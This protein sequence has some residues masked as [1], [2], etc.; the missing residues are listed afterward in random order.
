[1]KK[2]I[3][4]ICTIAALA[5]VGAAKVLVWLD[6]AIVYILVMSP[7]A[8]TV[9]DAVHAAP[10]IL[11]CFLAAVIGPA[12]G[13]FRGDE[14]GE[15]LGKITRTHARNP[16]YPDKDRE[17]RGRMSKDKMTP[18]AMTQEEA[19]AYSRIQY[20]G[21]ELVRDFGAAMSALRLLP[22]DLAEW[23]MR[24]LC[25]RLADCK[26]MAAAWASETGEM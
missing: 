21:E 3:A 14:E 1:M 2:R 11:G 17:E 16:E 19:E 23:A 22:Q 26:G 15:D 18:P 9:E 20:H 10:I 12:A 4:T 24:G 5:G 7:A 8:W 25:D 6:H 13:W